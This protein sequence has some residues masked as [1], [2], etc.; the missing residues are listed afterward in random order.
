MS[1]VVQHMIFSD[2][3]PYF[4]SAQVFGILAGGLQADARV[5]GA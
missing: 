2:S 3:K 5:E 1:D 4:E